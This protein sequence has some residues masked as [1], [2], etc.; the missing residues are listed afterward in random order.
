MHAYPAAE[1][2]AFQ[3]LE[4]ANKEPRQDDRLSLHRFK[5]YSSTIQ[6]WIAGCFGIV[7]MNAI[8]LCD[9]T[10]EGDIYI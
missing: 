10:P 5:V 2:E 8:I 4:R 9:G 7:V 1:G 6:V 3:R